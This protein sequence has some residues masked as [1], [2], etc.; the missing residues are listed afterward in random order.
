MVDTVRKRLT[1]RIIYNNKPTCV[2]ASSTSS[3]YQQF[4]KIKFYDAV[5][6][7]WVRFQTFH[8]RQPFSRSPQP[9]SVIDIIH[10]SPILNNKFAFIEFYYWTYMKDWCCLRRA[11]TYSFTHSH[12]HTQLRIPVVWTRVTDQHYIRRGPPHRQFVL[13]RHK[14]ACILTDFIRTL[15]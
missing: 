2:Q 15:E 12:T 6:H 10:H 14:I 9:Y 11:H 4:T 3:L 7:A 13:L 1:S 8:S 5:P